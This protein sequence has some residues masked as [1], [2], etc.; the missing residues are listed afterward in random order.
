[1]VP[2]YINKGP[3]VNKRM[4]ADQNNVYFAYD[5]SDCINYYGGE[6]GKQ[7]Q[8]EGFSVKDLTSYERRI[9]PMLDEMTRKS[10]EE[11]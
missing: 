6:I 5:W 9:K 1:M 2:Y 7:K 11:R 3:E 8:F 10:Q 4:E